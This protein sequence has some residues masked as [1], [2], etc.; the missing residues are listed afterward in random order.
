M[1]ELRFRQSR[2]WALSTLRLWTKLIFPKSITINS[3]GIETLER[4]GVIFFWRKEVEIMSKDKLA[5][6]VVKSGLIWDKLTIETTG[7]SN[8][9][10]LKG[11][12]KSKAAKLKEMIQELIQK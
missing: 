8:A 4:L 5:S 1:E 2:L 10:V 9:L 7:G 6:V 12:S 11:Y 3:D